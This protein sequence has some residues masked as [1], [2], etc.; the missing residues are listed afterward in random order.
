MGPY[1]I[2]VLIEKKLN[3]TSFAINTESMVTAE[4]INVKAQI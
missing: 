1:A 4:D 2:H 3:R